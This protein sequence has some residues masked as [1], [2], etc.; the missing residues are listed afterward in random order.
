[1]PQDGEKYVGLTL[2]I[3]K[4]MRVFGFLGGGKNNSFNMMYIPL[5][6]Y[7]YFLAAYNGKIMYT[8][9]MS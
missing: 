8:S 7:I 6:L 3:Y 2:V 5:Y 1:M 4:S 9:I